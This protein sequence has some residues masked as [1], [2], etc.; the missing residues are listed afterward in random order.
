MRTRK[1]WGVLGLLGAVLLLLYLACIHHTELSHV[2]IMRNWVTGET[3]LDTPGWHVTAPWVKI[4]KIDLRPM[5]VCVTT[6]GKGRNCLLAQ[7]NIDHWKEFVETEGLYYYWWAN[8]ISL[9]TGYDEEYRGFKD[10][11]RG[12]AYA[13]VKYPFIS[14]TAGQ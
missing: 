9:N 14:A 5:R 13:T 12:Y 8:R 10:I 6:S 7:F 2:G 3:R 11:L 1:I 4:V